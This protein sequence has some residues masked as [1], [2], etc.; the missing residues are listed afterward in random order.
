MRKSIYAVMLDYLHGPA[1]AFKA[2]GTQLA[3][4]RAGK[5]VNSGTCHDF[6]L[7]NKSKTGFLVNIGLNEDFWD[8]I[9]LEK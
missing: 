6:A 3:L 8:S 4:Q 7:T 2:V 1:L 9:L 5:A